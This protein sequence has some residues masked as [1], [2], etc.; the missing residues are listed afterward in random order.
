MGALVFLCSTLSSGQASAGSVR[1]DVPDQYQRFFVYYSPTRSVSSAILTAAGLDDSKIGRSFA[2]IAGISKYP[3]LRPADRDLTPAGEDVKKLADYFKNVEHFDEIVVLQNDDV[4]FDN[5]AFFLQGYFPDKLQADPNSRLLIAYSGHGFTKG[6]S[7]FLV[8]SGAVRLDAK[9]P[10]MYNSLN[11]FNLRALVQFDR[12]YTHSI[13]ALLNTCNS[14][15]FL[16]RPFGVATFN[17]YDKSAWAITAGTEQQLAFS[18]GDV[19]TGSLF[20]EKLFA[21]LDGRA[22]A[23]YPNTAI[24]LPNIVTVD[25]LYNYLVDQIEKRT[26]NH[27]TPK[28]GDLDDS[29]STGLFYFLDRKKLISNN[30]IATWDENSTPSLI[31]ALP[32]QVAP[33]TA[34][35]SNTSSG[36][37]SAAA[38]PPPPVAS[39]P[40][41]S[42]SE[43]QQTVAAAEESIA[44]AQEQKITSTLAEPEIQTAPTDAGGVEH[45]AVPDFSVKPKKF[46]LQQHSTLPTAHLGPSHTP[47]ETV[48]P[49]VED[50]SI[51]SHVESGWPPGA[52]RGG[53]YVVSERDANKTIDFLKLPDDFTLLVD[54][55]VKEVNWTVHKLEFGEG[56]T[57]D[58]SAPR[59]TI[60]PAPHG[61]DA[62]V[63]QSS[64]AN[65]ADGGPGAPGLA[66]PSGISLNLE[67][68]TLEM[69]GNLW[70]RTDGASG[71]AGG[72]G[73]NGQLGGGASCGS[74]GTSHVSGGR[75]GNGGPGGRGGD[76]GATSK[77]RLIIHSMVGDH[78]STGVSYVSRP[79]C[80]SVCGRSTRPADLNKDD[81]KITIYGQSGCGGPGGFGGAPGPGGDEGERRGCALLKILFTGHVSGGPI[82][83]PG[84]PG[85]FGETGRCSEAESLR[86]E[87]FP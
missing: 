45:H 69:H 74:L 46:S 85:S 82:G 12:Q 47:S 41:A 78:Q 63:S 27:Q 51:Q 1:P 77:V 35:P 43:V 33:G 55:S 62:G 65:G 70:I 36:A 14:G 67:V 9:N 68:D 58:V 2:L 20:F 38:A 71:G 28:M 15:D 10:D 53:E 22:N 13:L 3:N 66:G 57:I 84:Q 49:T 25:E 60:P 7:S 16:N 5:L 6:S 23:L 11:L 72:R 26:S 40:A 44:G 76:G 59:T 48:L 87:L 80:S 29:G 8:T 18:Y 56:A 31:Q 37:A 4:T 86:D 73:G 42:S 83:T 61:A 52:V 24:A 32:S 50:A 54:S 39:L 19:G 17:I 81:G 21:A 34:E 30:L 64:G 75:G 79:A